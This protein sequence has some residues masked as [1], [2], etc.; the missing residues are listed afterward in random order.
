MGPVQWSG[1]ARLDEGKKLGCLRP[2]MRLAGVGPLLA[3][4]LASAAGGDPLRAL[5]KF[6]RA[7]AARSNL[8]GMNCTEKWRQRNQPAVAAET[9]HDG[10]RAKTCRVGRIHASGVCS[11]RLAQPV[12]A[13]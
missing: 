2:F 13:V 4:G 7:Y 8:L 3:W 6:D 5:K 9:D 12:A 11:S 1:R 10:I